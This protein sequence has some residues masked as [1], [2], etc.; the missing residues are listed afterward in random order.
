MECDVIIV[1]GGVAGLSAAI[2]CK[3]LDPQLNVMLLEKGS[4]VGAHILSGAVFDPRALNELF[5]DWQERGAPLQVPVTTDRFSLLTA[6]CRL[7]MP[8]PPPMKNHGN[9]IISLA[10][11]CRWLAG[12][13]EAPGRR[14]DARRA[15]CS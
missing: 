5:P 10:N 1:G 11:L 6:K 13:A 15:G 8:T 2:R 12:Q 3:Q 14:V 9:Y 4:E 7:G